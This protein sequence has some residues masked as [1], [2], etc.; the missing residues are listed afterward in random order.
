MDSICRFI[1]AKSGGDLKTVHF[2]LET[3]FKKMRQPFIYPI[4]YMHLVT[5]GEGKLKLLGRSFDILQG[6][7]FFAFPGVPYE[8]EGSDDLT[9]MYISYMGLRAADLMAQIKASPS[10]PV[11]Q[12]FE[13][14]IPFWKN[15]I[16]RINQKNANVLTE[17]V[18][19]YT[20]SYLSGEDDEICSKSN[21]LIE[22]ITSY[23]DNNYG[24]PDLSLKKIADIFAYT[25]KYLSHVF[26]ENTN[27]NFSNYLTRL[28]IKRALE[29]IGEGERDI[30][31]IASES[32]YRDSVYF[33]KVF[34]R[35]LHK[36]PNEYIKS[37]KTRDEI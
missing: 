3:E 31:R 5:K 25:D 1:P 37:Q 13:F 2:V 7:L 32:G 23:I 36:T 34:K 26:K 14:Q 21:N 16:Q 33:A 4:Y 19:L 35:Y 10:S 15:A 27:M 22:N 9:Y 17:S 12:N 24:D 28:R 30:S 11:I 6:S 8:I 20:L 18:L 29:L